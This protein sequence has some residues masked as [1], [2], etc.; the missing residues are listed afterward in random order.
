[1]APAL[2]GEAPRLLA[3]WTFDG[4][5][6]EK[7]KRKDL[8]G[9]GYTLTVYWSDLPAHVA[10]VKLQ[11]TYVPAKG[12]PCSDEPTFLTAAERDKA[13]ALISRTHCKPRN[14]R[15]AVQA[16]AVSNKGRRRLM[17]LDDV[18]MLSKRGI[19]ESVIV[20]TAGMPDQQFTLTID[21]H[22]PTARAWRVS[23]N[24]GSAPMQSMVKAI[25]RSAAS[26]AHRHSPYPEVP[27]GKGW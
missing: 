1:M 26:F 10:N 27:A 3:R 18:I 6:L 2:T 13:I 22:C 7:L 21:R 15:R 25:I 19:G 14:R 4:E 9:D 8:I 24:V 20:Q 23:A 17:T 16:Q 5:R 11:T 12:A